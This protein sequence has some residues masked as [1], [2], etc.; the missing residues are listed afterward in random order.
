MEC[1]V[2]LPRHTQD[3]CADAM[4]VD[5]RFGAEVTNS[6]LEAEVPVG[7]DQQQAVES[8]RAA[9]V[10][11]QGHAHATHFGPAPLGL[12]DA[13]FIVKRIGAAVEGFLDECAG[14][15]GALATN[16]RADRRLSFRRIDIADR[17]LIEFQ[18]ARRFRYNLLQDRTSL[19]TTR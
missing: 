17:N 14:R 8:N 11:A 15:V 4:N 10:T 2:W 19:H 5:H 1:V 3:L 12:G 7:L 13:F 16:G 9:D 18:L 6:R